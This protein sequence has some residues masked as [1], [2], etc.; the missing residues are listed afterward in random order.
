MI[1]GGLVFCLS[2]FK[3]SCERKNIGSAGIATFFF[4]HDGIL[5]HPLH[6]HAWN[7]PR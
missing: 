1:Q 3:D 7:G 6:L 4:L 5:E 2:G